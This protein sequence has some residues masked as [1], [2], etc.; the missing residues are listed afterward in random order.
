[1]TAVDLSDWVVPAQYPIY[2]RVAV[3]AEHVAPSTWCVIGG[4]M[5]EL[6]LAERGSVPVRTTTDG[7]VLGHLAVDPDVDVMSKIE[8]VLTEQLGMKLRPTGEDMACRYQDS[9]DESLFIDVLVP[10]RA[11]AAD[12]TPKRLAAPGTGDEQF[13]ATLSMRTVTFSEAHAPF[14]ARYP[15]LAGAFYAKATAWRDIDPPPDVEPIKKEKHLTDAIALVL[16][17]SAD[18]L[19]VNRSKGSKSRLVLVRREAVKPSPMIR[20]Q[21]TSDELARVVDIIDLALEP[22]EGA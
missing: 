4:L 16:S 18:E 9:E 11:R 10:S 13:L 21:F 6:V 1:M 8:L 5:T 14:D 12:G 19:A 7:D 3:I 20:T 22:T 17:A 15:S 2:E